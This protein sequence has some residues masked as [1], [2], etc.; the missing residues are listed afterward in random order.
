MN[1]KVNPGIVDHKTERVKQEAV[2]KQIETSS[3]S[4]PRLA[5]CGAVEV[6][7]RA[8]DTVGNEVG[9]GPVISLG[10]L[11]IDKSSGVRDGSPETAT[12]DV[13]APGVALSVEDQLA[14][15]DGEAVVVHGLPKERY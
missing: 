11:T 5:V 1:K 13:L 9:V 14:L 2:V 15:R 10:T 6:R 12:A 8:N 7:L 4:T 3:C